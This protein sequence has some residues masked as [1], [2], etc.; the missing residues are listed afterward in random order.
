MI[1]TALGGLSPSAH[2]GA[3]RKA[4][5]VDLR[6]SVHRSE[7]SPDFPVFALRYSPDGRKV[8]VIADVYET[9][10]GRMSRLL[11]I[12]TDHPSGKVAQFEIQFGILEDENG[13]GVALNFGW[14]PSG[15]II[16]AVGK[17]IHLADATTCK[18]PNQSV[19]IS[20]HL[21]IST[22]SYRPPLYSSST[23]VTFFDQNCA[24]R[25]EWEVPEGWVISDVS[26][27]RRLLSVL[28]EERTNVLESLIVDP[29]AR[30]VLQRW[31]IRGTWDPAWEFADSGKAV[32]T[33][34]NVL[35]S[36]RAPAICRNVDTGKEISETHDSN[37]AE[38]IATAARASRLVVSDYRRKKIPFEYEYGATFKGRVAWDFGTGQQLAS[39][40]PDSET[41]TNVFKP[42]KQVTEPFRFAMSPDGQYVAEGGNGIVR[43]YKI[44]P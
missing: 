7:G 10:G 5:E 29:L 15:Q 14:A 19:F 17:V 20:D 24:M 32:C 43:L 1:L 35:Q 42:T 6:K 13:R 8:A 37:G 22:Q 23:K 30:R 41:Y 27:D 4:W 9:H 25:D 38:P 28:R 44:E 33:G 31:P 2:A 36:D 3:L 12:D 40:Y 34:A 21:A 39:W 11:V 18:L 16:Y 26:A